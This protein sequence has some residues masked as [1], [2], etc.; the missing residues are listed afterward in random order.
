MRT[1][2]PIA[3]CYVVLEGADRFLVGASKTYPHML[4]LPID[5]C[6]SFNIIILESTKCYRST[7]IVFRG[8]CHISSRWPVEERNFTG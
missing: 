7:E 1:V 5:A 8:G 3:E 4:V 6:L 2:I